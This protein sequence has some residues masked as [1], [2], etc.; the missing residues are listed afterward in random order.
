MDRETKR[1]NAINFL[2][3]YE[4]MSEFV[5]GKVTYQTLRFCIFEYLSEIKNSPNY[6]TVEENASKY[7]TWQSKIN[8]TNRIIKDC[9][10]YK[11]SRDNDL[12]W[13]DCILYSQ[14]YRDD[15]ENDKSDDIIE[16]TE[17]DDPL[18]KEVKEIRIKRNVI[19]GLI[20]ND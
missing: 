2:K 16:W 4:K 11:Y 18:L 13:K 10:T 12:S 3:G 14:K 9:G 1:S 6:M 7:M 20:R 8:P 15:K 5:F 19:K 17:E